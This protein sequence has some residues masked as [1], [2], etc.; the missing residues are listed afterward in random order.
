MCFNLCKFIPPATFT[1]QG[2][3][4][5]LT[6]WNEDSE[7]HLITECYRDFS[8]NETTETFFV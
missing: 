6:I 3:H 4:G 2:E 7:S 8:W 1:K 5:I